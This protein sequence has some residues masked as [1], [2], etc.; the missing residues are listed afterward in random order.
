MNGEGLA[1]PRD[2]TF[3]DRCPWCG[4]AISHARFLDIQGRIRAEEQKRMEAAR[5]EL[6]RR[7]RLQADKRI[8]AAT[9][10]G[11]ATIKAV[12]A[13]LDATV[14]R[15]NTLEANR[16][17]ERKKLLGKA[18]ENHKKE[19][20]RQREILAKA[21]DAEKIKLQVQFNR[22][23]EAYQKRIGEL[24]RQLERRT[25]N[26]LGDGAEIDLFEAL[27]DTFPDDRIT[28]VGKGEAGA[29]IV[30]RV[31]HKGEV[32]GTI[33]VDSKN[34]RGWQNAYVTKLRGDQHE[35]GAEF[36]VL[37]TTVF[38]AGKKELCI[39]DDV[40][41]V[42]PARAVYIVEMLR[43]FLIRVHVLGLSAEKRSSKAA[44]L[45]SFITSEEYTRRVG[46]IGEIA[47]KIAEVDVDEVK[48]H[49]KVWQ[50]RGRLTTRLRT[51]IGE[52]DA[53][54][55]AIVEACG[56]ETNAEER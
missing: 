47:V 3:L 50:R 7:Y 13:E 28:R 29:D 19:L 41:V 24:G 8:E 52:L 56:D 44:Q 32:C 20:L 2:E 40:V 17:A 27:R 14:R 22:E 30:H 16:E 11:A 37:S 33:I 39:E 34:R 26:E 55:A 31:L 9:A 15:A 6:E 21:G 18:E 43:R 46:E 38:P 5:T 1:L 36:A 25:A 12:R 45:Y 49:Q 4:S 35:A 53:E 51:I 54:V 48:D 23:R 42:N 10:K